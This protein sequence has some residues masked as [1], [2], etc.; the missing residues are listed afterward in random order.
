MSSD[1]R[2]FLGNFID[3]VGI[4]NGAYKTYILD[5]WPV[6]TL[7]DSQ[8][9]PTSSIDY[10]RNAVDYFLYVISQSTICGQSDILGSIYDVYGLTFDAINEA[11]IQE[12]RELK[13][14]FDKAGDLTAEVKEAVAK[15]VNNFKLLF[16]RSVDTLNRIQPLPGADDA[17]NI[18]KLR[19]YYQNL[20]ALGYVSKRRLSARL[21]SFTSW[22]ERN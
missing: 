7:S 9:Y 6:I 22:K 19:V 13:D 5:N 11:L 14:A 18:Q 17:E 3:Y 15:A 20:K 21:F 16:D 1:W 8:Q 10:I 12:L 4:S 2:H